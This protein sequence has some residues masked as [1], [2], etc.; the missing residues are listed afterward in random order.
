MRIVESVPYRIEP[1]C[2]FFE[3]CG[4]CQLQHI[5][6]EKQLEF[7]TQQV[8]DALSKIGGIDTEVSPII[9]MEYPWRYRNKG[10]FH[11]DQVEG[12]VRLGFYEPGSHEFVPAKESLLFS[13]VVNSLLDY[14]EEQLTLGEITVYDPVAGSGYLRNIMIRESRITEK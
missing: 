12:E 13:S 10:H 4:G 11:L 5:S 3:Q 1:P 6:Y 9:G 7:K 2:R 8:K 14:L